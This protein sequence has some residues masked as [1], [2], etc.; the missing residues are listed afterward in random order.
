MN[1][2]ALQESAHH[3]L[4]RALHRSLQLVKRQKRNPSLQSE[5]RIGLV[6]LIGPC[7]PPIIT[8]IM[9]PFIG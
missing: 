1:R 8:P 3:R 7:P 4:K 5:F 2:T 6:E 9:K